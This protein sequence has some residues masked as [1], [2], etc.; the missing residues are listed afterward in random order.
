MVAM[1]IS[2]ESDG[3][4][5]TRRSR[6]DLARAGGSLVCLLVPVLRAWRIA[7]RQRST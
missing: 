1:Y 7:Y 6:Q 4:P 5:A 3:A 2:K